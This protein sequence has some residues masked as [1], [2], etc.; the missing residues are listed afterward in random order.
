[1]LI[2][3]SP[4][5]QNWWCIHRSLHATQ[6]IRNVW[7]G[8]MLIWNECST[9]SCAHRQRP[10]SQVSKYSE[11]GDARQRPSATVYSWR[12]LTLPS[13]WRWH[14]AKK[15]W[16]ST[17]NNLPSVFLDTRQIIFSLFSFFNQTFCSLLLHYVDL[18]VRFWHNYR[19]DCYNYY[20]LFV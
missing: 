11:N 16:H 15:L 3:N 6:K 17:I 5:M 12:P 9:S 1:M 13:A 8:F 10:L 14:S 19:S 2:H 7:K 20:I 18:H 4:F